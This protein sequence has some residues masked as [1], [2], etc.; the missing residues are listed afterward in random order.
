VASNPDEIAPDQIVDAALKLP[1]SAR[2]EIAFRILA[3]LPNEAIEA[4]DEA[5]LE[6]LERRACDDGPTIPASELWKHC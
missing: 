1:E 4:C 6:E 5:F 2:R 3:S